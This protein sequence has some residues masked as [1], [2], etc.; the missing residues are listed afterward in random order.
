MRWDQHQDV[1]ASLR[2]LRLSTFARYFLILYR[3]ASLTLKINE[4]NR[5]A[6]LLQSREQFERFL[7]LLDQYDC[8]SKADGQLFETFRED[9]NHFSTAP[10]RDAA[11]RRNMKIT[12]FKAEKTLKDKLEVRSSMLAHQI[13]FMD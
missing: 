4:I 8:L 1:R 5:K 3:L 2:T 13:F 12:R 10:T 7:H 9:R 6:T 11:S